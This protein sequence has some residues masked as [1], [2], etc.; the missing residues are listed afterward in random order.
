MEEKFEEI[1]LLVL[2]FHLS[3]SPSF[4]KSYWTLLVSSTWE[5][6][7][8]AAPHPRPLFFWST[9]WAA[10]SW[11]WGPQHCGFQRLTRWLCKQIPWVTGAEVRAD[12]EDGG[13]TAKLE[14]FLRTET[15]NR[16]AKHLT[17]CLRKAKKWGYWYQTVCLSGGPQET[18]V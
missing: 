10:G 12:N 7:Q 17:W 13:V 2:N 3:S 16:E 18:R 1:S 5:Q 15:G 14:H 11:S 4:P 6:Q 9:E 8:K